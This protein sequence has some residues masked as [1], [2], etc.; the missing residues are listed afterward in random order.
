MM[1]KSQQKELVILRSS[2]V[3]IKSLGYESI[4]SK[5]AELFVSANETTGIA[6]KK[7]TSKNTIAIK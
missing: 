4:G 3:L 5:K 6:I 7:K 2:V 1:P